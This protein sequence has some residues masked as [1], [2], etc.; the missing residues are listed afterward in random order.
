MCK[1][2]PT[3]DKHVLAQVVLHLCVVCTECCIPV[4][5]LP[6][7]WHVAHDLHPTRYNINQCGSSDAFAVHQCNF[8]GTINVLQGEAVSEVASI[9]N[10]PLPVA[11]TLLMHYMWDKEKLLGKCGGLR[12]VDIC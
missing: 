9:W 11:K 5:Q 6:I 1:C 12:A 3:G 8:A 7:D 2:V 4:G 10:C